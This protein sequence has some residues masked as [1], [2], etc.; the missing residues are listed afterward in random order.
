MSIKITVTSKL[1]KLKKDFENLASKKVEAGI[2]YPE[3]ATIAC[4]F[5]YGYEYVAKPKQVSYFRNVLD[6]HL[7]FGTKFS[8]PPRPW[9]RNTFLE[10]KEEWSR[11]LYTGLIKGYDPVKTLSIIGENMR[12]RLAENMNKHSANGEPFEP[13]SPFTMRIYAQELENDNKNKKG[14]K[15]KRDGTGNIDTPLA[16]IKTGLMVDSLTMRVV[17][18]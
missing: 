10:F 13:R 3:V 1:D 7:E 8:Q 11:M 18:K 16:G 4:Y 14:K 2:F 6:I 5:E 12:G 9:F 17:N 15:R